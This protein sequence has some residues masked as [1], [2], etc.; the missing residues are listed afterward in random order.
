[1]HESGLIEAVLVGLGTELKQRTLDP[2]REN[3]DAIPGEVLRHLFH[4]KTRTEET[5]PVEIVEHVYH[6]ECGH[7]QVITPEDL[8][9]HQYTCPM[10]GRVH[11][12]TNAPALEVA[13]V[14]GD[15]TKVG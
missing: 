9:G 5:A 7:Q 12:V 8:D 14:V 6:C 11:D 2:L 13:D 10:C 4:L 1:M 3:R 15:T